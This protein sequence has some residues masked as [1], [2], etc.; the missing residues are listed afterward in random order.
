V[1][2][3]YGEHPSLSGKALRIPYETGNP[4]EE[5]RELTS[6]IIR[7][8]IR[9]R[10][11][12]K[13]KAALFHETFMAGADVI[14][15][16]VRGTDAVSPQET[17]QY[18]S[19]SLNL[20]RYERVLTDLLATRPAAKLLIATDADSSLDRLRATFGDRVLAYG[21]VRHRDGEAVGRGP[22]GCIMPAYITAD[23]ALAAQN[24]EDAIV[25]YLLLA[26]CSH[27]V[28]NGAGLATTVLLANPSLDHTNTHRGGLE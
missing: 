7:T 27:L 22:T 20:E 3:H 16:H 21:S 19:G 26:R 4:D 15:V 5:L 24:G 28:H 10:G 14:G 25:E 1:T 9:P 2:N 8:L 6:E 12:L 11:Y 13:D 17:R 18:R 23:P